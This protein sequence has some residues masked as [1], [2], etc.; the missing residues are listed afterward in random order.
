MVPPGV[1]EAPRMENE[2][3]MRTDVEFL[4]GGVTCRG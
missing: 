4:S 2:K 1:T 3:S